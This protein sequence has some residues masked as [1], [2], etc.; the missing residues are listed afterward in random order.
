MKRK[1]PRSNKE[2][3]NG[4][5]KIFAMITFLSFVSFIATVRNIDNSNQED[6]FNTSQKYFSMS[7]LQSSPPSPPITESHNHDNVISSIGHPNDPHISHPQKERKIA[8]FYNTYV[9]PKNTA[10]GKSIIKSQLKRINSSLSLDNSTI[11]YSRFGHLEE[12]W[13]MSTCLH[14]RSR[15]CI[16]I[17]EREEGDETDTLQYLYE[18]CRNNIENRVVYMH[19]KGSFTNSNAN[20]ILNEVLMKA[21]TSN[22]CLLKMGTNGID[23]NTCSSQF[24][25]TFAFYHGNMWVADCDYVIKLIPPN[26]FEPRKSALMKK[27]L[28]SVK[29][30]GQKNSLL[31]LDNNTS[32][33]FDNRV[34]WQI[35][36]PSWVGTERYAL[37]HWIGSHPFM[38]P[39]DVFS[40]KNGAPKFSYK[41]IASHKKALKVAEPNIEFAPGDLNS[42]TR[43]KALLNPWF[44]SLDC[45]VYQYKQL[46][47]KE[48][49]K[50]S[51]VYKYWG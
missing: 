17:T 42:W 44:H 8:I 22:E 11:Y 5:E 39:C 16:A 10:L 31:I 13:P 48:P 19:T 7:S 21:I 50:S 3:L 46:Y 27:V 29:P 49:P 37:E 33:K 26:E 14:N 30:L 9:N 28:N 47:S 51:W 38:K 23:C 41:N 18:Y 6:K 40:P 45:I 15:D 43:R 1:K 25:G 20:K 34:K 24:D 35:E 36:R 32:F 2:A 12:K 4:F